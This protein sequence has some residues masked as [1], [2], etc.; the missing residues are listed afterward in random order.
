MLRKILGKVFITKKFTQCKTSHILKIDAFEIPDKIRILEDFIQN[1]NCFSWINLVPVLVHLKYR[2]YNSPYS[3][4]T[5]C[6]TSVK[7]YP[8]ELKSLFNTILIMFFIDFPILSYSHSTKHHHKYWIHQTIPQAK[9]LKRI[10]KLYICHNT[11]WGKHATHE[12]IESLRAAS[13]S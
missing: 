10:I 6:T 1:M 5:S 3:F 4:P 8:S 12:K 9:Q 7:F 2:Y 13:F 11:L